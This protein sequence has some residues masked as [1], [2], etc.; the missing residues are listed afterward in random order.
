[1]TER[2][3]ARVKVKN[4]SQTKKLLKKKKK[5]EL[6]LLRALSNL[7][8]RDRPPIA[9]SAIVLLPFHLQFIPSSTSTST[10]MSTSTMNFTSSA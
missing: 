7:K 1:M 9:Q 3:K 6:H 8:S 2:V 4:K 10:S 5:K